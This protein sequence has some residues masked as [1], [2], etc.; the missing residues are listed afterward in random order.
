MERYIR[1]ALLAGGLL[2]LL[3]TAGFY[4]RW[5]WA[6][7]TWPWPDSRLSYI[8]LASIFAAIAAPLLWLGLTGEFAAAAPGALNLTVTYAGSTAYLAWLYGSRGERHLLVAAL[9]SAAGLLVS[10][11]IYWRSYRIPLRDRRAMPLPVRLSFALFAVVLVPVGAALLLGQPHIFP[12]P[13]RPESSV[14]F[15]WIFLGAAV[16]FLYG[17]LRPNWSNAA[18]QLIGFLVYDL[19]LIWPFLAHF[20]TVRPE[21]RRSLIVYTAF[22]AYSAGLAGYYLFVHRATRLGARPATRREGAVPA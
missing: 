4:F 14:I 16:Y 10:A 15:G 3:V 13:L 12:W 11:L 6:T 17:L 22:L 9:A 5:P 20:A 1:A 8:F 19:L 7:G 21:H 2:L 18:G